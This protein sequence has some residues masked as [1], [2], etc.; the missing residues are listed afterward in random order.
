M[1]D[2]N[3]S[4]KA[5]EGTGDVSSPSQ[6]TSTGGSSSSEK[7]VP[8]KDLLVLKSQKESLEQKL[9]QAEEQ[10]R[11]T[12][13]QLQ[14]QLS[15]IQQR[16]YASEARAKELE[17]K[18]NQSASSAEELAK[19]KSQLES[20]QKNAEEYANRALEFRRKLLVTTYN[21]PEE[22]VKDKTM[23]QLDLYEEAL[24]AVAST[25]G[26]GSYATGGGTGAGAPETPLDR[27]RRIVDEA[28]SKK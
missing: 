28:F 3:N 22:T 23:E 12:I 14:S 20:V 4:S 15:E 27:A 21:I 8:E 7:L 1:T 17:E 16:Q 11:Q 18:L 13:E 6:Q 24:K 10:A 19:V 26:V 5:P 9:K 25:K 2:Q